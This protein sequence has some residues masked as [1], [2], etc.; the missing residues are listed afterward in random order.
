MK[1]PRMLGE[2]LLYLIV[3]MYG[4]YVVAFACAMVYASITEEW[5]EAATWMKQAWQKLP[6]PDNR[7]EYREIQIRSNDDVASDGSDDSDDSGG[8]LQENREP[9]PRGAA[10][11]VQGEVP[12]GGGGLMTPL[13]LRKL[14]HKKPAASKAKIFKS[15]FGS[16][17]ATL[18]D[19]PI[20]PPV[21]SH[22]SEE[23]AEYGEKGGPVEF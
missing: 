23:Y 5:C 11:V 14:K 10:L 16:G 21:G 18:T 19:P 1:L 13:L 4:V 12:R 2:I 8:V 15:P 17:R 3:A 9:S 20:D 22:F 7:R 6:W